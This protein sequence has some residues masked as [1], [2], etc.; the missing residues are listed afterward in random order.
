M[1]RFL[2][3]ILFLTLFASAHACGGS[4]ADK[5]READGQMEKLDL[6][7]RQVMSSLYQINFR[8]NR[9]SKKRDRLSTEQVS[10]TRRAEQLASAI[11]QLENQIASQRSHLS[12][13]LRAMYMIGNE[14]VVRTIFSASNGVELDQSLRYLKII[15]EHDLRLIKDYKRN[16][17][18]LSRKKRRLNVR[19]RHLLRVRRALAFQENE[20]ARNQNS[21]SDLL[22]K[23]SVARRAALEQLAAIRV[24]AGDS[25][26]MNLINLS[27]F[28]HKGQMAWPVKTKPAVT[29][30]FIKSPR[31]GYTLEHKGYDFHLN[32]PQ[33]IRS[34]FSGEVSFAGDL[35]GYD[36]VVILDHGDHYYSVYAHLRHVIV[37]PGQNVTRGQTLASADQDLYFEIRHFSDAI[38]PKPWLNS[39]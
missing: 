36:R 27:F 23:L 37:A 35:P 32:A 18:E 8:M 10:A 13:R 12:K 20:L 21:K 28:D 2:K 9:V 15:S 24:R 29:Y 38:N 22:K 31:Y 11:V 14:G 34:I 17:A 5:Y 4:L 25:E 16:V 19:V 26:L 7:S 6:V 39:K 33:K 3:Y 30:G 1:I